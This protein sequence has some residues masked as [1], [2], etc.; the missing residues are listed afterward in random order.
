MRFPTD[1][2][3]Y[4]TDQSKHFEPETSSGLPELRERK[5]Y[6]TDGISLLQ[7]LGFR[8]S[9][10]IPSILALVAWFRNSETP[11][12]VRVSKQLTDSVR[13]V[14][15]GFRVWIDFSP[16]VSSLGLGDAALGCSVF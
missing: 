7:G 14:G 6:T 3:S 11:T 13:N 8:G 12:T 2:Q 5:P 9:L 10:L 16:V 4:Q 1:S 15:L